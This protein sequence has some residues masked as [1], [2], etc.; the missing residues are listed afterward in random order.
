MI[1]NVRHKNWQKILKANKIKLQMEKPISS[2]NKNHPSNK[3]KKD[4][5]SII[6]AWSLKNSYSNRLKINKQAKIKQSHLEKTI[7]NLVL[8]QIT[9]RE[10]LFLL[11][12][13]WIYK[14][15]M[16]EIL[17]LEI[18]DCLKEGEA[19]LIKNIINLQTKLEGSKKWD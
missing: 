18:S 2:S 12:I 17:A 14:F 7:N 13:N 10:H 3:R 9:I 16:V 4:H 1:K 15:L 6:S 11:K 5:S 8:K 19:I